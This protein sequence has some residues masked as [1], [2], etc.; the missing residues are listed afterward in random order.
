MRVLNVGLV[1]RHREQ[2][3]FGVSDDVALAFLALA[4]I[5]PTRAA[6]CGGATLWLSMIPA[7]A[8]ALRRSSG[9]QA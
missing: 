7:E 6:A 5:D 3:A 1:H 9:E 2:E 4:G 8:V